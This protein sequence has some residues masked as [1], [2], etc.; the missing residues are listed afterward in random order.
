MTYSIRSDSD[1]GWLG[2]VR[3]RAML[4]REKSISDEQR[5]NLLT[6]L[7]DDEFRM[8]FHES[9]GDLAQTVGGP[10]EGGLLD[11]LSSHWLQILQILLALL[12]LFLM[13]GQA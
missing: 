5:Q 12:P 1:F 7:S 11:W 2:M 6:A 8:G 9:V 3:I 13:E 10:I 4:R